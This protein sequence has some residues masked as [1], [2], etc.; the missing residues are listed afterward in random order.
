MRLPWRPGACNR[1]IGPLLL[2]HA[3]DLQGVC[4]VLA[5][6]AALEAAEEEEAERVEA[7][8]AVVAE[9]QLTAEQLRVRASL[10]WSA[11]L[12]AQPCSRLQA[13][14]NLARQLRV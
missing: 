6:E 3:A 10:P 9:M 11:A 13:L 5:S 12:V 14:F 2:W 8:V 1:G 7:A 4:A